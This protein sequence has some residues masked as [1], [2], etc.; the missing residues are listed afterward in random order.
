MPQLPAAR[1]SANGAARVGAPLCPPRCTCSPSPHRSKAPRCS[2]P[3]RATSFA[4]VTRDRRAARARDAGRA[5]PR[6]RWRSATLADA[7]ARA[8]DR[9]QG[10][11]RGRGR[12]HRRRSRSRGSCCGRPTWFTL[13]AIA[14]LPFRVPVSIG[15]TAAN[16]LLPLYARDRRRHPRRTRGAGCAA[17]VTGADRRA[18]AAAALAAD[19]VRGR[20]RSLRAAVAVLDRQRAGAEELLPLLRAVRDAVPAA[21][22][23]DVVAA[24]A[25]HLADR[26][27]RARARVRGD[28][29]RRVRHRPPADHQREGRRRRTTSCP[30]S[31]STRC[32]STRTSTAA[33][34]R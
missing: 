33:T 13:L 9:R 5:G 34:W 25:A 19:R 6:G 20:A 7:R 30:T 2:P 29:L 17:T 26:H 1:E 8:V 16:L 27:G 11:R 22:R 4:L 24:T 31:G 10:H 12:R 21:A 3:R 28:R 15:D 18:R 23:R 14:A 32:S